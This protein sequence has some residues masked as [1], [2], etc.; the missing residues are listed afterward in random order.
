MSDWKQNRNGSISGYI[1]GTNRYGEGEFVTTSPITNKAAPA[2]A[3]VETKSGSKYFL[4]GTP[5]AGRSTSMPREKS[6]PAVEGVGKIFDIELESIVD[7]MPGE[8]ESQKIGTLAFGS[9]FFSS[10]L[11]SFF[12]TAAGQFDFQQFLKSDRF[13]PNDEIV[14]RSDLNKE[15]LDDFFGL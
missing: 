3:V 14:I 8:T 9:L 10:V 5:G 13:N 6:I 4:A 2:G 12:V 11:T 7:K 15:E 1:S